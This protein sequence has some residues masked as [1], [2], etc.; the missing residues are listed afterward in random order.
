M[1]EKIN[2]GCD[3]ILLERRSEFGYECSLFLPRHVERSTVGLVKRLVLWTNSIDIDALLLHGSDELYEVLGIVLAIVGIQVTVGPRIKRFL[4]FD[5][6][7]LHPLRTSP[8]SSNNLYIRIDCQNFL[9][10]WDNILCLIAIQ[11]EVIKSGLIAQRVFSRR[12]VVATDTDAGIAHTV[13][14]GFRVGLLQ[15]SCTILGRHLKQVITC[16]I[17]DGKSKTVHCLILLG[18]VENDG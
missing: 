14:F 6:S 7:N 13:A 1:I 9:K 11:T 8:W 4:G 16:R 2:L 12:E 3:T 18:R 17:C 15:E 10:Y 5:I